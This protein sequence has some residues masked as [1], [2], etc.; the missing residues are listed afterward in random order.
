MHSCSA[1]KAPTCTKEQVGISVGESTKGV[2]GI[3]IHSNRD[4]RGER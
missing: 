3:E 2:E 4:M 1:H